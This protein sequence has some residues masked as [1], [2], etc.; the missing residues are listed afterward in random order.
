VAR[1]TPHAGRQ[2]NV[3]NVN[4][5]GFDDFF[6]KIENRVEEE[7]GNSPF[8]V[9]LLNEYSLKHCRRVLSSL[10]KELSDKEAQTR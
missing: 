8:Q 4:M 2:V 6:A 5:P 3:G 7:I 1:L 10:D 9:L